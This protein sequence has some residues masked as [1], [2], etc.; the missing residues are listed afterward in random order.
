MSGPATTDRPRRRS[1]RAERAILEATLAMLGEVGF[2]GLSIDGIAA[3]AGVGKTTIYRHWEGK[4]HLVV[5]AFRRAVPPLPEPDTGTLRDDLV[6]VLGHVAEG[7]GSSALSRMLPALVEA[8]ERD[9]DLRRLFGE[10][11]SERRAVLRRVLERGRSRGEMAAR[12][13]LDLA[14]D[15]LM[16]PIFGRRLVSRAPL[17]RAF[18]VRLVDALMPALRA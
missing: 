9:A 1:Q 13:D 16:G 14:S 17:D 11:G 6:E 15:M 7:L 3:R 4:A 2:S 5:D 18:A 10:F 8:A 12:F